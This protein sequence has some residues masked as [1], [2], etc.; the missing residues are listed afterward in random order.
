M[1]CQIVSHKLPRTNLVLLDES[2]SEKRIAPNPPNPFLL[3]SVILVAPLAAKALN[4][5]LVRASRSC[6]FASPIH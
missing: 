3:S 4:K 6:K 5:S 2:V 1:L